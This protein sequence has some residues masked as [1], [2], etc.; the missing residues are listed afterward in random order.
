MSE[1]QTYLVVFQGGGKKIANYLENEQHASPITDSAWL[2]S[3]R[4]GLY[5]EGS[6]RD[7]LAGKSPNASIGV[8]NVT[9]SVFALHQSKTI[10]PGIPIHRSR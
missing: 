1:Q 8:F 2:F 10:I 4:D 5:D 3:D 6:L 7:A 9:R